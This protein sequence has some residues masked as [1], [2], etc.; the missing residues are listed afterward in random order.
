MSFFRLGGHDA[1]V[2]PI[3]V[4]KAAGKAKAATSQPRPRAVGNL[5]LAH[6]AE[7]DESEF[8]KF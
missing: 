2:T 8:S 1:K 3:G 4:K 7:P 6:S 5:A